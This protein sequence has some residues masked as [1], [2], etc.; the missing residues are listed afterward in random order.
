MGEKSYMSLIGNYIKLMY[1]DHRLM[2]PGK[3]NQGQFGKISIVQDPE[4][5]LRPIAMLDYYSQLVLKKVHLEIFALLR[6]IP[7]DRTFTQ[8]P[9][10]QGKTLGHKF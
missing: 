7:Q 2:H 10:F 4:L 5:K 3:V 9:T 1:K 8:D 6:R